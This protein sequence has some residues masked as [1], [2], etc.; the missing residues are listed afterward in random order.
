MSVD[1]QR[2]EA[3]DSP[4]PEIIGHCELPPRNS[5]LLEKQNVLLNTEPSLQPIACF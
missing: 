5:G 4:G 1:A 3:L 2:P